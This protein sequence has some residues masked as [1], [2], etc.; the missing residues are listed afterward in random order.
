MLKAIKSVFHRILLNKNYCLRRLNL[1]KLIAL[2]MHVLNLSSNLNLLV[3]LML[4]RKNLL[5]AFLTH[6]DH[7]SPAVVRTASSTDRGKY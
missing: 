4:T 7:S 1:V 5:P 3:S 2:Y 6:I